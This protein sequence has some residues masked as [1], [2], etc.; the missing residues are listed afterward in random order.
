L[1]V[2]SYEYKDNTKQVLAAFA[3]AK[4]RGLEAIGKQKVFK[5]SI[6]TDEKSSFVLF[7]FYTRADAKNAVMPN[8]NL[9]PI[10][11]LEKDKIAAGKG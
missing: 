5:I 10:S 8:K 2:S 9:P 11:F 4:R 6:K 1:I 3:K 7:F